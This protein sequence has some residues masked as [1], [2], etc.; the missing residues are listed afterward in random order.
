MLQQAKAAAQAAGVAALLGW[1][2]RPVLPPATAAGEKAEQSDDGQTAVWK[3]VW[4]R[5]KIELLKT[6]GRKSVLWHDSVPSRSVVG[7]QQLV[8]WE[9]ER[10]AQPPR[11]VGRQQLVG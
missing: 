11:P 8:G 9:Q 4:R 3:G 10:R 5:P 2:D 6:G 7:Q 1:T